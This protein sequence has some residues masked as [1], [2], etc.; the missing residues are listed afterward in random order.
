[1][2]PDWKSRAEGIIYGIAVF[3]V[4]RSL[5]YNKLSRSL[6]FI[7]V[8]WLGLVCMDALRL[9]VLQVPLLYAIY[10]SVFQTWLIA[11]RCFMIKNYLTRINEKRVWVKGCV[12]FTFFLTNF[13]FLVTLAIRV[14]WSFI[15]PI[16][17]P[18]GAALLYTDFFSSLYYMTLMLTLDAI[19]FTRFTRYLYTHLGVK[20]IKFRPYI[21]HVLLQVLIVSVI[22]ANAYRIIVCAFTGMEHL[23]GPLWLYPDTLLILSLLDYGVSKKDMMKYNTKDTS[24]TQ[25]TD[26]SRQLAAIKLTKDNILKYLDHSVRNRLQQFMYHMQTMKQAAT[27][28]LT[29]RLCVLEKTALNIG[30]MVNDVQVMDS[31]EKEICLNLSIFDLVQV[32]NDELMILNDVDMEGGMEQ[33]LPDTYVILADKERCSQF[34]HLVYAFYSENRSRVQLCIKNGNFE[35]FISIDPSK[36]KINKDLQKSLE[37][38]DDYHLVS[39]KIMGKLI[40]AMKGRI[41]LVIAEGINFVIPLEIVSAV[42]IRATWARDDFNIERGIL[43]VDDSMINR[44]V[45]R[46]LI[47]TCVKNGLKVLDEATN[48]EEAIRLISERV[49]RGEKLYKLVFMDVLMPVMDGVEAC[50]IIKKKWNDVVVIMVTA[51]DEKTL[52]FSA[53][54]GY[55]QKPFFKVD[56]ERILRLQNFLDP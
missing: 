49:Q 15:E 37:N 19:S 43:I 27:G 33:S 32:V 7:G 28:N 3:S 35:A 10:I 51:N 47:T 22:F 30:L 31:M 39:F 2:E 6:I 29:Q 44:K 52:A 16:S 17:T 40:E 26:V 53:H 41:D 14:K 38:L 36:F 20:A 42:D 13:I 25:L 45:M 21:Y 11:M 1:M 54:D 23:N 48:G 8:S 9:H 5:I 12:H 34:L 55:L 46:K 50:K 18:S 56:V 4:F 24:F